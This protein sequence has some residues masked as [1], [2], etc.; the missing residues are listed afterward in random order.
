MNIWALDKHQDIRHVLLLLQEQLGDDA[1]VIDPSGSLDPRTVFLRHRRDE[2]VHCW[3]YTLGQEP[4]RY[5]V[6]LEYPHA[7]DTHER[8]RLAS[9]A[10]ILAVHF[11]VPVIRPLPGQ[12]PP[13]G[14]GKR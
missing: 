3:L 9:L 7:T 5:G 8:L 4:G 2:G 12:A 13:A 14:A 6:H 11:D 10:A 1:F